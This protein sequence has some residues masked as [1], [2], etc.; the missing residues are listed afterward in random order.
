MIKINRASGLA[1][2]SDLERVVEPLAS[3]ICATDRPRAA[4]I[5]AL[6]I[7]LQRSGANEPG[8]QVTFRDRLGESL[9]MKYMLLI[10]LDELHAID[11]AERQH[12]YVESAQLAQDLSAKGQYLGANPLHPTSTA[13]TVRVRDGRQL[14]T[15]GPFAETREQLGGYFLIEAKDLDAALGIAAQIPGGTLGHCRD[16]AGRGDPR[17]A[18]PRGFATERRG[19]QLNQ[20]EYIDKKA[21]ERKGARDEQSDESWS[22]RGR[23]HSCVRR[24]PVASGGR[25][26]ARTSR[27][28]R[29]TT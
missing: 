19:G 18:R 17:S 2:E 14:V 5:S 29:S 21:I 26:A 3:F 8:G 16:P 27:G 13:T 15:D 4:L 10:Y 20:C 7:L 12:C 6:A 28:G 24:T 22:A 23:G 1:T 9:V 11:D 25:S